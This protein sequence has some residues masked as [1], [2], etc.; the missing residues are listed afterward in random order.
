MPGLQPVLT[1]REREILISF[2]RSMSYARI[3][4]ERET[5]PLTARNAV[6]GIQGNWESG[7]CRIWSALP[8][9][10]AMYAQEAGCRKVYDDDQA[11]QLRPAAIGM[12][13]GMSSGAGR[14]RTAPPWLPGH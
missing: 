14:P 8:S 1:P 7:R 11:G 10:L 5:K 6:Y 9:A 2:A 3:E 13:G 4:E 12:A